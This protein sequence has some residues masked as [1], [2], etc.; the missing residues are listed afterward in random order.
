MNFNQATV[1]QF[2]PMSKYLKIGIGI[3]VSV[4]FLWLVL[5]DLHFG[6]FIEAIRTIN[7]WWLFVGLFV[8][9]VGYG[10]R[11]LR[12]RILLLPVKDISWR[13]SMVYVLIG[14][15]AN[16]TLPLRA[17]EFVRPYIVGA[18]EN[19]SKTTVFATIAAERLFDGLVIVLLTIVGA[20]VMPTQDW[21]RNVIWFSG[22]LF[23]V[24]LIGFICLLYFNRQTMSVV[25]F[26]LRLFP[27]A[28]RTKLEGLLNVFTTGL[29]FLRNPVQLVSVVSTSF[30]IWLCEAAFY[31]MAAL[32]FS[33]DITLVQAMFIM[34]MLNLAILI[35]SSPGYVGTFEYVTVAGLGLL[36]IGH[37][38]AA[39]YALVSHIVQFFAI[40]IPGVFLWFRQGFSRPSGE[41]SQSPQPVAEG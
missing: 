18:K 15:T 26:F 11:G 31:Y 33:F 37:S 38:Q 14:F 24:A 10:I 27:V 35:P 8:W 21:M 6:D 23:V 20:S 1:L 29:E 3:A 9:L 19:I 34:G 40:N 30:I 16:N 41:S 17:G 4:F 5:K 12:A 28:V 2:L 39:G 32:A 36:G 25:G 22:A 7:I 13:R